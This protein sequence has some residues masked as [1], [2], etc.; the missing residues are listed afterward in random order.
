M[1]TRRSTAWLAGWLA[2]AA[3]GCATLPSPPAPQVPLEPGE[4]RTLLACQSAMTRA[5]ASFVGTALKTLD[6]CA[7]RAVRLRLEEDRRLNSTTIAEFVARRQ[8]VVARC[9]ADFARLGAAST[10][11]VDGIVASCGAVEDLLLTDDTRGD[12]L[13]FRALDDLLRAIGRTEL[14]FDSVAELAGLLCGADLTAAAQVVSVHVPRV[15]D[16]AR[17]YLGVDK[18]GLAGYLRA[19]ADPRCKEVDDV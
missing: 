17:T 16:V 13:S 18:E 8:Q 4:A 5:S 3:A 12:P 6:R 19:F 9:D 10:R 1:R 14:R 11:L 7:S 2:A 15:S